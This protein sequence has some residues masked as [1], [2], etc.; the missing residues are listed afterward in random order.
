MDYTDTMA[1]PNAQGG[2]VIENSV[3]NWIGG[4]EPEDLNL[5]SGNGVAGI[6]IKGKE[7]VGN[8]VMG[9]FIGTNI[10]G[11]CPLDAEGRCSADATTGNLTGIFV[12]EAGDNDI[13]ANLV[14]GNKKAG[15]LIVSSPDPGNRVS[16]N[17]IGVG[18]RDQLVPNGGAGIEIR[19]G[20]SNTIGGDSS[21][22]SNIIS[23]NGL[24][25]NCS[26]SFR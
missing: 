4:S 22:V 11:E 19:N 7:S 14:S 5:I 20:E 25:W 24:T 16:R 3:S 10:K 23:G 13:T 12:V 2:V 9:N 15:I 18:L 6:L 21:P 1:M 26:L 17:M 8:H